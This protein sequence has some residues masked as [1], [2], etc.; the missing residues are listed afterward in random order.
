MT[1]TPILLVEDN[2]HDQEF[3]LAALQ[4]CNISQE[5]ITVNDG[6]E[7]LH[8]LTL[9]GR[10]ATRQQ[11]NPSLILL[12]LKLPKIDGVELL[13]KIRSTPEWFSIPIIVLS[14]SSLESDLHRT[15]ML[16]ISE[17]VIKSMDL[18][19]FTHSLC[20]LIPPLL[21]RET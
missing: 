6:E 10:Y 19:A 8:Y 2:P 4:K 7:A 1:N 21:A 17:Y 14:T 3:T 15:R 13:K 11:E 20:N 5:V 9:K 12:D 16:G 18:K